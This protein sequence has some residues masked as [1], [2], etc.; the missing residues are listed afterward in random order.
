MMAEMNQLPSDTRQTSIR[1]Y[2]D[3][4]MARQGKL[5]AARRSQ[6][7]TNDNNLRNR[8]ANYQR[9]PQLRTRTVWDGANEEHEHSKDGPSSI[10]HIVVRTRQEAQTSRSAAHKWIRHPSNL[11]TYIKLV[12]A[13]DTAV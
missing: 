10:A 7:A 4:F 3:T 11:D 6:E 13:S 12:H 5:E 9:L 2:I 1:D 8:Y